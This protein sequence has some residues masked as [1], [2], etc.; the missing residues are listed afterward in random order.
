MSTF[1]LDEDQMP[2]L[3]DDLDLIRLHVADPEKVLFTDAQ[4]VAVYTDRRGSIPRTVADLL[5][6]IAA[7]ELLISKKITSQDLSTDGPA[8]ARELRAQAAEWEARA[9]EE[10]S[11]PGPDAFSGFIPGTAPSP[12]EGEERR[13]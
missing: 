12:R 2:T 13:W 1:V 11:E 10:E 9:K 7:S 3:S 4:V 5:R 8:V 6:I